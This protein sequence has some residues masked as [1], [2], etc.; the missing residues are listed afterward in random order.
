MMHTQ[1]SGIFLICL[2]V[3]AGGG[4]GLTFGMIQ[5]AAQQRYERLQQRGKFNSGW[6]VMPGSMKRVAYLLIALALV[7][8][9]C[10]LLFANGIQWMVSAGVVAGYGYT[11]FRQF[12]QRMAQHV[13]IAGTSRAGKKQ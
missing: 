9:F 3:V 7:Q 11:L 6:A 13:E 10:P 1:L 8:F 2:A 12:R 4:I 5:E